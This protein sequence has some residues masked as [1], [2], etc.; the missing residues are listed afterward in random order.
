MSVTISSEEAVR[1]FG[2]LVY[3]RM[4]G[5]SD[6]FAP[7]E[8]PDRLLLHVCCGPCSTAPLRTLRERGAE[9]C[10]HFANSNIAPAAEY[11]LR[12]NT[13]RAYAEGLGLPFIEGAYEPDAWTACMQAL[14]A[15]ARASADGTTP[16]PERCRACYRLRFQ[17]S[18]R[19]AREHGFTALGTT[20]SVSPYQYT[21]II[22]E[23][24]ERA[25]T[26]AGIDAFF[27]DYSPLY[28]ETVSASK[29]AGLYR[30]DYCGCLPSK[31]E[32]DRGREV[33]A[34]E[35]AARKA[36]RARAQAAD[37]EAAA[38]RRQERAA[39]EAKQARKRAAKDALRGKAQRE[40]L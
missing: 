29:E 6:T 21:D 10:I 22:Q 17:E 30:Q 39:Y 5:S 4:H 27:E 24:L 11:E 2:V 20:L 23:E 18:A 40:A 31:A 19:Y 35:R 37:A 33:R 14:P 38:A 28:P 15:E 36:E 16:P 9:I 13:A 12:R 7:T 25:C 3:P 8:A 34:A 26:E 1:L 32:A